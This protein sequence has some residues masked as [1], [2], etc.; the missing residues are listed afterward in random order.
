[1]TLMP[2]RTAF[3]PTPRARALAALGAALFIAAALAPGAAQAQV[4]DRA[5]AP[6]MRDEH[7]CC[8][9]SGSGSLYVTAGTT[10][11]QVLLDGREVGTTPLRLDR[12]SAG[13]HA[14]EIHVNGHAGP[15]RSV[16]IR[17]NQ[18]TTVR[19]DAS[20]NA[21]T[22]GTPSPPSAAQRFADLEDTCAQGNGSACADAAALVT[23]GGPGLRANPTR[24]AELYRQG[25]DHGNAGACHL[26][27]QAQ[28]TGAGTA[29]DPA[30]AAR[31]ATEACRGGSMQAC[32][33]LARSYERGEGVRLDRV[34]ALALY[35]QACEGGVP[36]A[37]GERDRLSR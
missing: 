2:S 19:S 1:M 32:A 8:P 15:P 28:R 5:C 26:L 16:V 31:V 3:A 33:S 20:G 30:E 29:R 7:G 6:S 35:R 18:L 11:A 10:R 9:T 34:R 21:A 22:P 17:A 37:C 13:I 25:C 36:N 23:R 14:V 4:C 12:I 27:A 24:A